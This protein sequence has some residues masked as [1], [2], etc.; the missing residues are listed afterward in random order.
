[1]ATTRVNAG[2]YLIGGLCLVGALAAP[3]RGEPAISA[4]WKPQHLQFNYMGVTSR[5]TCDGLRDK[6]RAMLLDLGVRRDLKVT[7]RG[8]D[9]F[10]V[11]LRR[12]P[13]FPSLIIDFHAAVPYDPV[14]KPAPPADLVLDASFVPFK[15]SA[16]PF[17]N[18]G[19]GECELVEDVVRQIVPKLVT[20]GV[21][22]NIHCVPF[23]QSGGSYWVKG[24]ILKPVK[25]P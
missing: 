25:P 5:Y 11:N 13:T 3:V 1:M 19:P 14:A 24:D 2:L 7:A 16:D 23:Q 15:I 17:R 4:V 20:R 10:G 6:V 21:S 9:D 8:C 22:Q 18:M 12:A